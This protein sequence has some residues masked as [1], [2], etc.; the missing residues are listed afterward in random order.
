MT[1]VQNHQQP[2]NGN[3]GLWVAILLTFACISCGAFK[4]NSIDVE[5]YHDK[6]EKK[7]KSTKVVQKKEKVDITDKKEAKNLVE[8]TFH[9]KTYF[10]PPVKK[11]FKIAVLLPF[12]GNSANHALTNPMLDFLEGVQIAMEDL[13]Q[14]GLNMK[15][16]VYDTYKDSN[17]IKKLLL[18][19]EFQKY[20]LIIGPVFNE[21]I[22]LMEN[23]CAMF[24]IP[25][26]VPLKYYGKNTNT[27][28]PL[29]NVFPTDSVLYFELGKKVATNFPNK[30]VSAVVTKDAGSYLAR[31]HFRAGYELVSKKA[32]GTVDVNNAGTA[33]T[34]D[35][36]LL[37]VP[38]TSEAQ[39][40][41]CL[42]QLKKKKKVQ[43]LGLKEWL[44]FTVID[45]PIWDELNVMYGTKYF[46]NQEDSM[47]K[48]LRIKYRFK[49]KGEPSQY[50]YIAYDEMMFFGEALKAF[51]AGFPP[52][53][54]N[55]NFTYLHNGFNF[56]QKDGYYE[57][58]S[59]N[60]IWFKEFVPT[61]VNE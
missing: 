13:N 58:E 21:H 30:K 22:K 39:M 23:H 45:Y 14:R 47:V 18:L 31:K 43:V 38:T 20:D 36:V 10:V 1:S 52:Y 28:F 60:L 48:E 3:K 33:C 7:E 8:V 50:F 59:L 34:G 61:K 6:G 41:I 12:M 4:S 54:K 56:T 29:F 32:L 37:F 55:R 51:G 49:Y 5:E 2:S 42:N 17:H 19:E 16:K 44:D 25:L 46:V 53:I 24:H 15:V 9:D 35:S 26:V 11:D 27:N 40:R 57:N